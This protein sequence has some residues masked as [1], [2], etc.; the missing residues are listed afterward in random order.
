MISYT[1]DIKGYEIDCYITC[2]AIQA[3]ME[4]TQNIKTKNNFLDKANKCCSDS[5]SVTA[6]GDL[7][8]AEVPL[9]V[10]FC[11]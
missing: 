2:R 10:K 4:P 11:N 5:S 1:H 3:M 6:S 8:L 9:S 7:T